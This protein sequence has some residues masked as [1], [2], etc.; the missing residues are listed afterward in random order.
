MSRWRQVVV[1]L[2]GLLVVACGPGAPSPSPTGGSPRPDA[3]SPAASEQAPAAPSAGQT[4][5]EWGPIWDTVPSGFPTYP[6]SKVAEVGADPASEVRVIES[7]DPAAVA[8]WVDQHLQSA[9]FHSDGLSGPF[10][11][12]SYVVDA[13]GA[14]GCRVQ[15]RVAPTGGLSTIVVLYGAACPHG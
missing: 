7:A 9:A 13:S 3:T 10:E 4:D 1:P 12:G 15:V 5:T 11:D 14:G 6:G 2:A 8:S